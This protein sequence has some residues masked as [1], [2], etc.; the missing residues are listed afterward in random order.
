MGEAMITL[1]TS[2]ILAALN[3]GDADHSRARETLLGERGP[4]VVPTGI[5]AEAGYMIEADLGPAVLRQFVEDADAGH[6][7]VDCGDGDL[8][9]IVDLLETFEDLRLGFAD[10]CVIACAERNGGRVLTFD[11]RDFGPVARAGSI[12]LVPEDR[13]R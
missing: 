5:L 2:A 6:Y 12:Q 9:R 8:R 13:R 4:L 11:D 3:R 10:A 1:D 7:R